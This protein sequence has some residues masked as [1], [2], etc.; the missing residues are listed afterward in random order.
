[1]SVAPNT[2]AR[3]YRELIIS[4][5]CEAAGRSGTFIAE[6]PPVAPA[7]AIRSEELAA[8][9]DRF[10]ISVRE[11]GVPIDEALES[12]IAAMRSPS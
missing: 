11:L 5:I 8:A 7:I 6:T 9:A 4:G 3:V 12:V 1:V 2:I 10:A